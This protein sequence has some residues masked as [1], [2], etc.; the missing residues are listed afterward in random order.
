MHAL[1]AAPRIELCPIDGRKIYE[2]NKLKK[3]VQNRNK[4]SEGRAKDLHTETRIKFFYW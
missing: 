3:R 1:P 4:D 2:N